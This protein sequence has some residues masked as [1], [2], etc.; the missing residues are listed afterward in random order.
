MS[1]IIERSAMNAPSPRLAAVV[2]DPME[3]VDQVIRE[4]LND[5]GQHR[6][7]G[8]LQGYVV[9]DSCDCSDIVLHAVQGQRSRTITQNLGRESQGCRLDTTAL[10]EVAGWL[11]ADLAQ[12]PDLLVLNR[13]GKTEAEGGGLRSVME[14]AIA[15]DIPVLV[16]VNR[17]QLVFWRDYCADMA[18]ELPLDAAAIADWLHVTLNS[19]RLVASA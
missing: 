13:F 9:D 3:P 12:Q 2:F 4:A 17:K 11:E 14:Q 5:F 18:L 7:L 10:A 16:P 6:I 19:D 15:G 1:R 8:W